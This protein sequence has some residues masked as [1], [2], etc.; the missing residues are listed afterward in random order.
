MST[1]ITSGHDGPLTRRRRSRVLRRFDAQGTEVSRVRLGEPMFP[2]VVG[3]DSSDNHTQLISAGD[4]LVVVATRLLKS[5]RQER[6]ETY[7]FLID[8]NSGTSR[9][10]WRY[11]E[12]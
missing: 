3:A 4:F 8:P 12:H 11:P 2:G 7:L 6:P 5:D 10:T 1:A 9:L